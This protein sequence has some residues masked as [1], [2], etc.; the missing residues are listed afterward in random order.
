MLAPSPTVDSE[1][2]VV[3]S[4]CQLAP[5]ATDF[6]PLSAAKLIGNSTNASS[7]NTATLTMRTTIFIFPIPPLLQFMILV[8]ALKA[9]YL[10]RKPNARADFGVQ[11][12]FPE[13]RSRFSFI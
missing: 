10:L 6:E 9:I 7:V 5:A 13:V 3:F 1:S 11:L 2:A 8:K 4:T 12:C